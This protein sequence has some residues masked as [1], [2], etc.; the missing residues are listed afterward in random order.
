MYR[1][2]A[3]IRNLQCVKEFGGS[4]QFNISPDLRVIKVV[5][6]RAFKP[7]EYARRFP[8]GFAETSD[9]H[10]RRSPDRLVKVERL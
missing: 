1:D 10:A 3:H 2:E 5:S 7:G 4:G 9:P 6:V 8:N